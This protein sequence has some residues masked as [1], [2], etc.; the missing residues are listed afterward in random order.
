[1]RKLLFI[2]ILTV[3]ACQSQNGKV[4]ELSDNSEMNYIFAR[5]SL[6]KPIFKELYNRGLFATIF[7]I[8]DSRITPEDFSEG[9]E[10]LS[11][12]I[13]SMSPDGDYYT[14]SRLYKIEGLANPKIIEIKETTY[15]KFI[16]K[17]EHGVYDKRK[18]ETF[19]FEGVK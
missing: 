19:E 10:F 2:L 18:I 1:M 11:S 13:V 16:I 9:H 5:I 6:R 4:I 14:N 17:I 7:Q 15:P 3:T 8:S 12:Y